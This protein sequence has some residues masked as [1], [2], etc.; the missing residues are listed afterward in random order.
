MLFDQ[1]NALWVCR[2]EAIFIDDSSEP[3]EPFLPTIRRNIV[4]NALSKRTRVWRSAEAFGFMFQYLA[5]YGA[6]HFD[7]APGRKKYDMENLSKLLNYFGGR[8][9]HSPS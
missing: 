2:A 5:E 8:V 6:C 1:L 4:V 7:H 3:F 9:Y